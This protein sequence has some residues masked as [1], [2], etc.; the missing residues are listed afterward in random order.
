[1]AKEE[2]CNKRLKAYSTDTINQTSRRATMNCTLKT[3]GRMLF[4]LTETIAFGTL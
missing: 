3:I 4:S 2:H 1:M